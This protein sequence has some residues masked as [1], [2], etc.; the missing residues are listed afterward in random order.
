MCIIDMDMSILVVLSEGVN[1]GISLPIFWEF[2]VN[3]AGGGFSDDLLP[4]ILE[5]KSTFLV[6]GWVKFPLLAIKALKRPPL[7][8]VKY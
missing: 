7:Q 5:T 2:H 8:K 1:L 6:A 4:T 3:L